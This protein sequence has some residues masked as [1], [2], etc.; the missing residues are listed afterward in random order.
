MSLLA[1]TMRRP[2]AA[3]AFGVLLAFSVPAIGA[4]FAL[5]AGFPPLLIPDAPAEGAHPLGGPT[6]RFVETA[7][8]ALEPL[9]H[10]LVYHVS[11]AVPASDADRVSG[12]VADVERFE[13]IYAAVAA[14]QTAGGL[15][16][17]VG[18]SNQN[19]LS[20][21]EL[22]VAALPFG[23]EADEF[24]AYLFDGGG[25]ALQQELYD[26]RFDGR[27][28]VLPIAI[29]PTQGGG[30]FPEP[31]PDPDTDPELSPEAAMRDLCSKPWIVRWPEPGASIWRH[32]CAEVGTLADAIGPRSRCSTPDDPCPG[33]DNP[34]TAR[35]D[36]L[37]FGGFVP[38]VPPHVFIAT[39]NVDAY[40]LNLPSTEVLMI[41][42][43]TGQADTPS[44]AADLGPVIEPAP[45]YYGQT[46]HQPLTYLELLINR[47]FWDGLATAERT[48]FRLAAESATLRSWTAAL[49]R[50]G[51]AIDRL[52]A[53][54]AR[55]GRWPEGLLAQLR[56]ATDTYLDAKAAR[57]ATAGD[58]DYGRVL[59][60]MRAYQAA[61]QVYADFGD[62]NQGRANLPTTPPAAP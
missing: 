38:G 57:L 44:A 54:G 4:E 8:A 43:A 21:G 53:Y 23:M 60:H 24:A 46:W 45:Y 55:I 13:T 6:M 62:L 30:W 41:R 18:I 7:N 3:G 42:L 39:G 50:Q 2:L 61:Q 49:A 27:V 26:S 22:H 10:R 34:A 59:A 1:T 31:L 33:P 37:S 48:A 14:G 47:D 25:L 5:Q 29:T 20:F 58:A 19:G 35:I 11:G 12:Q 15:D 32:A 17:G 28:V 9:G 52:V 36:R 40:E 56:R 51:V 16:L